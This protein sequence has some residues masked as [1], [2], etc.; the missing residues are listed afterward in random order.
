M[1]ASRQS[2]QTSARWKLTGYDEL[3]DLREAPFKETSVRT[4]SDDPEAVQSR[5]KLKAVLQDLL[6]PKVGNGK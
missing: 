6:S 2:K 3:F 4:S 1:M 5:Q